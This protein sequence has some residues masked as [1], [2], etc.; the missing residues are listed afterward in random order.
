[1]GQLGFKRLTPDNWQQPDPALSAF[2]RCSPQDG[3]FQPITGDE[4]AQCVLNVELNERVPLEVQRLFAVARGSLIYGYF[5][6]PL[7]TLG[8]E[9]LFRVVA[10]AVDHKCRGLGMP[11][12]K[13]EK[14][15]FSKK[16]A[17]LVKAEVIP[18]SARQGWDALWWLRN[19]AS[20]PD[21]Q[22]I[23]PPGIVIREL[24]RIAIEIDGLFAETGS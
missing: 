23:L 12:K 24:R 21:D 20:H 10:A 2:V 7:Y 14:V 11:E 4:W 13:L 18:S 9:Q 19:L 15:S 22:M 1:M 8:A 16:V 3:S 5:F 6:Y 17:H